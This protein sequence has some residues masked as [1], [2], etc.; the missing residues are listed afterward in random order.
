MKMRYLAILLPLVFTFAWA[1]EPGVTDTEVVIGAHTFLTGNL[2]IYGNYTKA[3]QAYYSMI[4]DQGGING[5]KIKFLVED[6]AGNP[7][8]ALQMTKKLVE[9]DNIFIMAGAIGIPHL[10]AAKYLE[11]KHI[12]DIWIGDLNTSLTEPVVHTRFAHHP[13]FQ[14]EAEFLANFILKRWPGKKIGIVTGDFPDMKAEAAVFKKIMA[15]KAE[16]IWEVAPLSAPNANAQVLN[17]KKAGAEVVYLQLV[18]GLAGTFVKFASEQGY[19]PQYVTGFLS[20]NSSYVGLLGPLAEGTVGWHYVF[21]DKDMDVPGIKRHMEIMAKYAP[22]VPISVMTVIGQAQAE[23][24]VETLTRAG[25][26]LTRE[27]VVTAAESFNNW[28]CTVCREGNST[29]PT[30]H[31]FNTTY[32]PL[33]VKGGKWVSLQ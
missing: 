20:S 28:K 2:S 21:S 31:R 15:G 17:L 4:N 1:G 19:K 29:S 14:G 5:R 24:I 27:G 33:V 18:I 25:K 23:T 11:G 3:Q 26:N 30:K 10:P 12:P 9:R 32:S 6:N 16:L 7:Q 8:Q 22:G 13:S